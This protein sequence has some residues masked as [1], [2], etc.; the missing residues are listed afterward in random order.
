MKSAEELKRLMI[1]V[2]LRSSSAALFGVISCKWE[3]IDELRGVS[4]S[5]LILIGLDA[6]GSS[7]LCLRVSDPDSGT[8]V[9][10]NDSSLSSSIRS[11]SVSA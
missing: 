10:A 6:V 2:T 5:S 4:S 9:S 7:G 11:W 8:S 1:F 3:V